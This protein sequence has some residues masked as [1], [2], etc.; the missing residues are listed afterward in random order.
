MLSSMPLHLSPIFLVAL[1]SFLIAVLPKFVNPFRSNYD[2]LFSGNKTFLAM[3]SNAGSILSI[4]ALLS[5]CSIVYIKKFLLI[6]CFDLGVILGYLVFFF[7]ATNIEKRIEMKI[8]DLENKT[9]SQIVGGFFGRKIVI[10]LD[11]LILFYLFGMCTIE[12]A[13]LRFLIASIQGNH[14]AFVPYF[15]VLLATFCCAMYVF[16][17]GFQ[18]VLRTDRIQ[19]IIVI[20][21]CFIL[22]KS[23]ILEKSIKEIWGLFSDRIEPLPWYIWIAG[24]LFTAVFF[25]LTPD[26]W[27]RNL[28]TLRKRS[29]R[30]IA[31][32]GGAAIIILFMF[33]PAYFALSYCHEEHH[34]SLT[35][36]NCLNLPGVN[37]ILVFLVIA[38][39]SCLF[40]TTYDTFSICFAHS[41]FTLSTAQYKSRISIKEHSMR[42]FSLFLFPLCPLIS[43]IFD[44]N[45][46]GTWGIF[47]VSSLLPIMFLAIQ[48]ASGWKLFS[49]GRAVIY[50]ASSEI[51]ASLFIVFIVLPLVP[52]DISIEMLYG[53]IPLSFFGTALIFTIILFT[54]RP[55]SKSK[56]LLES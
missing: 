55:Q 39:F 50:L 35:I 52:D 8:Y 45:N 15:I 54:I 16:G 21:A 11:I 44:E 34:V 37:T 26:L 46:F 32:F 10:A 1:L 40:L 23:V 42:I 31:L 47:F 27:V 7:L 30:I 48:C 12:I 24:P 51:I 25:S 2:Y 49:E 18:G 5:W 4:T 43:L 22:A 6:I 17:G 53:L 41:C 28:G 56:I 13:V 33:I 3:S 19:L 36:A 9:L 20:I 38:S 29:S 14:P